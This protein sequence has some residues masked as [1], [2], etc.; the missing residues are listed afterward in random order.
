MGHYFASV[1]ISNDCQHERSKQHLLGGLTLKSAEK[2]IK[3]AR[4]Q[5]SSQ[6]YNIYLDAVRILIRREFPLPMITEAIRDL[7][8]L[9]PMF[10]PRTNKSIGYYIH[11]FFF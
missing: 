9:N 11:S 10:I 8:S 4:V 2:K 3:I 1:V 6:S 5:S 7:M